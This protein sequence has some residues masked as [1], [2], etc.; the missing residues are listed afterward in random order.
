LVFAHALF[1]PRGSLPRRRAQVHRKH[2]SDGEG[3]IDGS[4]VR[5]FLIFIGYSLRSRHADELSE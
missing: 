2:K 4:M 5:V 1:S 3:M